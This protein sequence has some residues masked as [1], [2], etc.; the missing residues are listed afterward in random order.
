MTSEV[1]IYD[2]K[3]QVFDLEG[4]LLGIENKSKFYEKLRK[5]Y[6]KT[7]K[8]TKQVHTVRVFVMNANGGIYLA[9]RSR[10]KKEN[11]LLYDKTIGAHIRGTES[12]VYTVLREAAEELGFPAAA[13]SD[14]EFISAIAETDLR[15]IGVF[16]EIETL[17]HFV[18]KYKYKDGTISKFPQITTIFAGIFDGP[19]KFKDD[20]TS[21]IEIY[22]LDEILD[23]IKKHPNKYT[24]D[25]K[26]LVP[27]YFEVFK[28]I[29][30][31]SKK[32][33]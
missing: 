22:Y 20:E 28:K 26:I 29:A 4:K 25:V 15:T 23:E 5:D 6:K 32:G 1:E 18:T 17:N 19:V 3:I 16:K 27:K 24:E 21:G 14:S 11:T 31:M 12:P 8:V 33:D 2:E 7:G 10:L 30:K 9:K 13:L